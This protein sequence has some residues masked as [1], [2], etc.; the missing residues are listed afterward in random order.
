M[1]VVKLKFQDRLVRERQERERQ[2]EVNR[3]E[4]LEE[5]SVEKEMKRK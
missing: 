5:K 2:A 4:Q 3:L 1:A